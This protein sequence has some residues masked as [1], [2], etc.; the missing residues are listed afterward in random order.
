[1]NKAF[2]CNT[3]SERE[4]FQSVDGNCDQSKLMRER[5]SQASVIAATCLAAGSSGLLRAHKR[6]DVCIVD[7]AGQVHEM[8]T[9]GALYLAK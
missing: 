8:N 5:I 2:H 3:I 9:I 7:E 4:G 1:V 6:F